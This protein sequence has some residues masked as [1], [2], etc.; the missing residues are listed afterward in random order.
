MGGTAGLLLLAAAH[1]YG[2]HLVAEGAL[3]I[4]AAALNTQTGHI[5]GYTTGTL[6]LST[7]G[8]DKY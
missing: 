5:L 1:L 7:V 4:L 3:D 6:L 8:W 2:E